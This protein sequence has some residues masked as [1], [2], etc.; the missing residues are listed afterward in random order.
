MNKPKR[1]LA[2]LAA[3]LLFSGVAMTTTATASNGRRSIPDTNS[4]SNVATASD[5]TS[6]SD[7]SGS[8]TLTEQFREQAKEKL[9][10]ARQNVKEQSEAHREQSCNARKANLTKRMSN[11]VSRAQKHKEVFDKIYSRVKDFYITKNL[12]VSNYADLTAKVDTASSD[13]QSSIDALKAL[14]V[15]VDCTSQ[16]VADSVSAFQQAVKT[17]RDSLKTYRATL[18]DL[19]KSLKGAST[20]ANTSGDNSTDNSTTN[21]TNQ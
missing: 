14:D 9:Q 12:N 15:N 16:T 1:F 17:T 10:A 18:V 21:T 11:A 8:S 2:S 3:L 5:D 4:S 19:I 7:E 13:A 20:G 6:S